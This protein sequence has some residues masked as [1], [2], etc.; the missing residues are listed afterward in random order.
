MAS[1][2][3][4]VLI[5]DDYLDGVDILQYYLSSSGFDVTVA[6]DGDEALARARSVRPRSII[7]DIGLPKLSGFQ[8]AESLRRD[9]QFSET[10]I[11]AYSGHGGP[12]YFEQAEKS[13]IDYYLMKPA[14]PQALLACLEPEKYPEIL[15]GGVVTATCL[16]LKTRSVELHLKIQALSD[17]SAEAIRRAQEAVRTAQRTIQDSRA[18]AEKI[19]RLRQ[20]PD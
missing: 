1:S 20:S 14:D 6:E 15:A 10:R 11:I 5:A 4:S 13:G 16:D 8:V 2:N 3:N 7:L 19:R 17:R 12:S 18:V 9:P